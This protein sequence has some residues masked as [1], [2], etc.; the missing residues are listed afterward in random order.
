MSKELEILKKHLGDIQGK[1]GFKAKNLVSQIS[2]ANDFIGALQVLNI[3]LKKISKNIKEREL[4]NTSQEQKR[5]L[6]AQ[7][8]QLIQNC[9]FMGEHLFDN[10][11]CLN[12]ASKL[13]SFEI[14]NPLLV[15]E[16]NGYEGVLA[17]VDDK[18]E[19]ISKLLDELALAIQ[20][21]TEDMTYDLSSEFN[22]DALF[23]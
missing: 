6:D 7:S 14:Q 10:S 23:R 3:S 21:D 16:K 2:D 13:F 15:L 4:E 17:Y 18:M 5:M 1:S 8:S 22:L 19:E 20:N 9:S 12:L 11:F